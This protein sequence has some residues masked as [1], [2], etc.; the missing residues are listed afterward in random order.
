MGQS[1]P[2]PSRWRLDQNLNSNFPPQFSARTVVVVG[3]FKR[4]KTFVIRKLL[5]LIERL[6]DIENTVTHNTI[7]ALLYTSQPTGQPVATKSG[8]FGHFAFLDSEGQDHLTRT[9]EI[10]RVR[11]LRLRSFAHALTLGFRTPIV[12]VAQN[13]GVEDEMALR[14]L[15]TI[16][17]PD[18]LQDLL[19]VHN[20]FAGNVS[21]KAA[22]LGSL[23]SFVSMPI[24]HDAANDTL[25]SW[26][27]GRTLHHFLLFNDSGMA[28]KAHNEAQLLHLL[29]HVTVPIN[30]HD[31]IADSRSFYRDL[32][33]RNSQ[34]LW[35]G[36]TR[37]VLRELN[38]DEGEFGVQGPHDLP[39]RHRAQWRAVFDRMSHHGERTDAWY[40]EYRVLEID[41]GAHHLDA[42]RLERVHCDELHMPEGTPVGRVVKITLPRSDNPDAAHSAIAGAEEAAA[43]AALSVNVPPTP[44]GVYYVSMPTDLEV[45]DLVGK[46]ERHSKCHFFLRDTSVI[47]PKVLPVP[48]E[49]EPEQKEPEASIA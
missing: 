40:R 49:R 30:L 34:V 6:D 21:N 11:R 15:A 46:L 16:L 44:P 41:V 47:L 24:V 26:F 31:A 20:V 4:G 23:R 1:Y 42:I 36:A 48:A 19:V 5:Q 3:K 29:R 38:G 18:R 17:P 32:T 13:Y 45:G 9:W 22:T 39:A 12:Y 43:R 25:T 35:A 14:S 10:S 8:L 7:A 27:N 37:M 33:Q 2:R 28:E